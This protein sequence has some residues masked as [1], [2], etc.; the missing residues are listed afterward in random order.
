MSLSEL[1]VLTVRQMMGKN[2]RAALLRIQ[3]GLLKTELAKSETNDHFG[4]SYAKLEDVIDAVLPRLND[5]GIVVLQYPIT[6]PFPDNLALVTHLIHVESGEE[7]LFTLVIPLEKANAQGI[8]SA[9]T[10]GRRYSLVTLLGLKQSDDDGNA[11]SS[12]PVTKPKPVVKGNAPANPFFRK[13]DDSSVSATNAKS[14]PK[15]KLFPSVGET[16][17]E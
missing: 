8:G 14:R 1:P 5:A 16:N 3:V 7:H 11:A 9:I 4:N 13:P 10:Y 12:N 6:P 17:A 15:G 2:L